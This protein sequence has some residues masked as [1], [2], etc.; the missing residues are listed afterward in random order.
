MSGIQH[1]QTVVVVVV[2]N[3]RACPRLAS[4]SQLQAS[5]ASIA[6]LSCRSQ[7][8]ASAA[9]ASGN[10]CSLSAAALSLQAFSCTPQLVSMRATQQ[11]LRS[12][13]G[14]PS[15]LWCPLSRLRPAPSPCSCLNQ[16]FV[17]LYSFLGSRLPA[18]AQTHLSK[19]GA[20]DPHG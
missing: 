4:R 16:V 7:S 19:V 9:S 12:P 3:S 2:R 20:A 1:P 18:V 15:P 14:L 6:G 17:S 11:L 5:A 8:Q 13:L 10:N